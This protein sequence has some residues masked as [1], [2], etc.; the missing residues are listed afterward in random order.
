ML[1]RLLALFR[2]SGGKH[3]PFATGNTSEHAPSSSALARG[4]RSLEDV[5]ATPQFWFMWLSTFGPIGDPIEEYLLSKAFGVGSAEASEWWDQFTGWYE[6]VLD[7]EDGHVDDPATV[8]LKTARG[9]RVKAEIHP[10]DIYF[11]LQ[12]DSIDVL[13]GNIGPHWSLPFLSYAEASLLAGSVD[14][15]DPAAKARAFLFLTVGV[16]LSEAEAVK[17]HEGFRRACVTSL[18][19]QPSFAHPLADAWV[20]A[21]TTEK[22]TF[23]E[24]PAWGLMT[25]SP[26]SFRNPQKNQSTAQTTADLLRVTGA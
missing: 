24:E 17:A 15:G 5:L 25:T 11:H 12:Y 7:D 14:N 9:L 1:D 23:Y 21:V 16:W 22:Y 18:L 19:V 10:G 13:I 4:T 8:S 26:W 20:R 6:G 3:A 2:R